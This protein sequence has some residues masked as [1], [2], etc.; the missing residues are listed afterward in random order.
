LVVEQGVIFGV[1]CVLAV[2]AL[3]VEMAA[4]QGVEAS[5]ILL[6]KL[7]LEEAVEALRVMER[8]L[9]TFRAVMVA[10]GQTGKV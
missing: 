3:P 5:L 10:K 8:M 4:I 9:L 2:Q 6:L 7:V 1:P